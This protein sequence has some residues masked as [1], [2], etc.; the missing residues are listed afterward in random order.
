MLEMLCYPEGAFLIRPLF[1]PVLAHHVFGSATTPKRAEATTDSAR[2]G[3]GCNS[4]HVCSCEWQDILENPYF[5][6]RIAK[7]DMG[8]IV[9]TAGFEVQILLH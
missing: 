1:W 2:N 9:Y 5:L 3:N 4:M 8:Q 7:L 6:G